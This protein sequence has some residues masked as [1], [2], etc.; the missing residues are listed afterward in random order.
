M[1]HLKV[2]LPQLTWPNSTPWYRVFFAVTEKR[3][4][5]LITVTHGDVPSSCAAASFAVSAAGKHQRVRLTALPP[6]GGGLW[7]SLRGAWLPA[8]WHFRI[9]NEGR[10]YFAVADS[11]HQ[12]SPGTEALRRVSWN[13]FVLITVD[14]WTWQVEQTDASC[15]ALQ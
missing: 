11:F 1:P 5:R 10:T 13:R 2:C 8:W 15:C 14:D 12:L 9:I 6:A 4:V 7:I 3:W